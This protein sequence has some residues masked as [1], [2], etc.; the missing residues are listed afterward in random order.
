MT[1]YVVDIS[2]IVCRHGLTARELI[3]VDDDVQLTS[4]S[5]C[6]RTRYR[7]EEFNISFLHLTLINVFKCRIKCQYLIPMNNDSVLLSEWLMYSNKHFL[8]LF[9]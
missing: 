2:F 1:C 9:S 8:N 7:S 4:Q 5:H 6:S 3:S